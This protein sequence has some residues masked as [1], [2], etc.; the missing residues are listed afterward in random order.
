V[1]NID[2][3]LILVRRYLLGAL[4]DEEQDLLEKQFIT[5]DEFRER[6]LMTED[7]LIE[8]YLDNAL[9]PEERERFTSHFL[10]TPQ[11]IQKLQFIKA[12]HHYSVE[13]ATH[14][15]PSAPDE[16]QPLSRAGRKFAAFHSLRNPL[17]AA[18]LAAALLLV[19]LFSSWALIKS[20][21][22]PGERGPGRGF[23]QELARLN[24]PN[25]PDNGSDSGAQVLKVMLP[26]V[27]VRGG[28]GTLQ[29]VRPAGTDVV[30]LLL[31]LTAD[32]YKSYRVALQK[33]DGPGQYVI[34]DLKAVTTNK[35]MAVSVRLPAANLPRGDYLLE[36]SG[37]VAGGT[38]EGINSYRFR[39]LD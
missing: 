26:P 8:D 7:E 34:N 15:P 20:W 30:Q 4:S 22:Q 3:E 17:L 6:V 35:G 33:S 38:Y 36:L 32:E 37:L 28:G 27:N 39:V 23:E 5:D 24:N 9:S 12:M 2:E 29:D 18:P 14:S 16:P 19:V 11:Q 21:K 25:N 10:A 1:D 31:L 13:E